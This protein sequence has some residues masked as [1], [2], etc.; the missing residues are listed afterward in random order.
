MFEKLGGEPTI[1]ERFGCENR[2]GG[3]G[4]AQNDGLLVGILI[5]FALSM[6]RM[7]VFRP[8]VQ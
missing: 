4:G 2:C 5:I 7:L 1:D 3:N 8:Q 6:E